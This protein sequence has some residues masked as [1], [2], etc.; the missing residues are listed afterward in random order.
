M[1]DVL[2][3]A[4]AVAL[5]DEVDDDE[6]GADAREVAAEV[7]ARTDR[8]DRV[9]LAAMREPTVVDVVGPTNAADAATG[10]RTEP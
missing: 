1:E 5:L 3:D 9:V 4:T 8:F 2:A 7:A 10:E 6:R